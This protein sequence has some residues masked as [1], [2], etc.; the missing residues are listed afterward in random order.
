MTTATAP[1]LAET[2]PDTPYCQ[3]RHAWLLHALGPDTR[4]PGHGVCFMRGCGCIGEDNAA[5]TSGAE[6]RRYL[7]AEQRMFQAQAYQ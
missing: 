1:T 2:G 7:E 5:R 3:C 4:K 6:E